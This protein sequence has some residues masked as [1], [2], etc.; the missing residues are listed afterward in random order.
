MDDRVYNYITTSNSDV[1]TQVTLFGQWAYKNNTVNFKYYKDSSSSL[2]TKTETYNRSVN[3]YTYGAPSDDNWGGDYVFLGW[4][5]LNSEQLSNWTNRKGIYSNE[6]EIIEDGIDPSAIVYP[7]VVKTAALKTLDEWGTEYTYYGIWTKT[8]KY[9]KVADQ[10]RKV[11][12][13][14]VKIDGRWRPVTNMYYKVDN[15]WQTE[16]GIH[17]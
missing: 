1:K 10:W 12:T 5:V 7:Y 4:V 13:V 3:T 14:Y 6:L 17:E 8:G 11:N 16:L 2:T 9:I 15:T